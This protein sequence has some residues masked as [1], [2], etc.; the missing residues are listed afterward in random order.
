MKQQLTETWEAKL[1]VWTKQNKNLIS[2]NCCL[3]KK[4]ICKKRIHKG[5]FYTQNSFPFFFFNQSS[6]VVWGEAVQPES[7]GSSEP[8]QCQ[9]CNT[10][11][12]FGVSIVP[13]V[14][15]LSNFLF[16]SPKTKE[17]QNSKT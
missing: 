13:P 15:T 17:P 6:Y 11:P 10:F 8:Q 7:K 5:N 16:V 3:Y 1:Q 14:Y 9:Y 4:I 12:E 2:Q